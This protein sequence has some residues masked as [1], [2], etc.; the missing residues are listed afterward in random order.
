MEKRL[1]T[2]KHLNPLLKKRFPDASFDE[3]TAKITVPMFLQHLSPEEII[4]NLDAVV[5]S[6][7]QMDAEY[8]K[9]IFFKLTWQDLRLAIHQYE[10][11]VIEK[12][13]PIG[14]GVYK[15]VCKFILEHGGIEKFKQITI[16]INEKYLTVKLEKKNGREKTS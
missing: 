1:F 10:N 7:N 15:E 4:S 9:K 12:T 8:C 3:D 2:E 13:I 6:K 14:T 5:N 16:D 11:S